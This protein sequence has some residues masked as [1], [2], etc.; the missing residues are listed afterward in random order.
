[1]A[2]TAM[3]SVQ[4]SAVMGESIDC[5]SLPIMFSLNLCCLQ[6]CLRHA[7]S[8]GMQE[9][10]QPEFKHGSPTA[11]KPLP[12]RISSPRPEEQGNLLLHVR[13]R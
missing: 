1:M 6:K 3:S 9:S 7:I 10:V 13:C 2:R 5:F 11:W 8:Q 12:G 4:T